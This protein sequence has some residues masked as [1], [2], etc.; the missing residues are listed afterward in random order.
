MRQLCHPIY[1]TGNIL[2]DREARM[3]EAEGEMG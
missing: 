1:G 2:E 3:Q